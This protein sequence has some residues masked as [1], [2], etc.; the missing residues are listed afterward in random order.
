MIMRSLLN[1]FSLLAVVLGKGVIK[2]FCKLSD[3]CQEV[4]DGHKQ[5]GAECASCWPAAFYRTDS[6]YHH[7]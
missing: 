2:W 7:D 5:E 3:T 6:L 4:R 1:Y